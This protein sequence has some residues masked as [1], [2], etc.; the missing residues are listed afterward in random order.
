MRRLLARVAS[1]NAALTLWE[2]RRPIL[3]GL[4]M[5]PVI[6]LGIWALAVGLHAVFGV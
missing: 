3:S 2:Q 5:A 4:V 6:A 1:A